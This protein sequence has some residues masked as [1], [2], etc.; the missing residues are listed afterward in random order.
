MPPPP[1]P[2]RRLLYRSAAVAARPEHR[3]WLLA[4]LQSSGSARRLAMLSMLGIWIGSSLVFPL[5]ALSLGWAWLAGPAGL[6]VVTAV[7]WTFP[8]IGHRR[9][10]NAVLR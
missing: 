6:F 2:W 5:W 3:A 9:R 7:A 8:G 4:D 10:L 1:S